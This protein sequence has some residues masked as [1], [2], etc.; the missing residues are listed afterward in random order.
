[1][2]LTDFDYDL[3]LEL[4]AQHPADKREDSRMMV[5][6][7]NCGS[8]DHEHFYNILDHLN[9]GD[10]LIMNNSKV[11][12]ARLFG[13]KEPTGAKIEILLI[14]RIEGDVWE[15]MVKP[16]KR[17]KTGDVVN[18]SD[19]KLF[20]AQVIGDGQEG[21]RHIKFIYE[22]I[23]NE[24]LDEF[25]KI[26]LP[27]YIDRDNEK[28][29]KDRYQTVYCKY[30]GSVA[31]PTAGLHFTEDILK[32]LE[33]KGVETGFVTLHVG[34][35]TFRPVKTETVEEH[36]MHFE[37]YSVDQETAD[38]I[39][40]AKEEGRR[41]ISV[42][43]T[44]TRTLES[45]ADADGKVIPGQRSTNLFIYPPVYKFKVVDGLLTNFHL[46]KSTLLMLISAFYDREKILEA[47]KTAVE[48]KYRFFS[49]GDCMLII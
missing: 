23:F 28:E 41:V 21:T 39:N 7:R 12:P 16:G 27:P 49:Y 38:R 29:D 35:G 9:P 5:L 31:A 20:K 19:E 11:I 17:L 43:T 22:G 13:I 1:M 34:I 42:G 44:S 3:P 26:P 14:K 45:A 37:E 40:K 32:K 46:P 6:D 30:E 48:Q 25:G 10:L 36:V 2:K 4:I 33:E 18:F 15:A 24:L 47:Y 8:I